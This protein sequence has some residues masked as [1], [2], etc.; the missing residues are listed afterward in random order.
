MTLRV[1]AALILLWLVCFNGTLS[2][3]WNPVTTQC[4]G[5]PETM[6]HYSIV[7]RKCSGDTLRLPDIPA[8]FTAVDLDIL[9]G[10]M[11]TASLWAYDAAGNR[12]CRHAEYAFAMPYTEAPPP[13]TTTGGLTGRYYAGTQRGGQPLLTRI[14][15]I[16]L[17]CGLDSPAPEVPPDQWSADWV[18]TITIPTTGAWTFYLNSEDGGQVFV[19]GGLRINHYDVQPLT[20]WSATWNMTAGDH[21]IVVTYMANN[22][23][24]E[25]HLSW[26]GP[27]A[28]QVVP[29]GALR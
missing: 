13:D 19:D 9:P 24:S 15:N 12:S 10:T 8:Q 27:I 2:L 26:S 6:G 22:G 29:K 7:L 17:T 16:D 20:E 5:T 4:D 25:A 14:E 3:Q 21:G 23:N 18:G 11:G 28:K 1:A